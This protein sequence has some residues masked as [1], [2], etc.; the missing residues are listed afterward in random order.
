MR[1]YDDLYGLV[2]FNE[3]ERQT[4]DHPMF[5]RLRR[6]KQLALAEYIFPGATHSRF[7]HSLGVAD[8]MKRL[9]SK[10]LGASWER[11]D[12]DPRS[13]LSTL[14]MAAL[15]HDIGHLPLSH[16][17]EDAYEAQ[18][19]YTSELPKELTPLEAPK[20]ERQ[21]LHELLSKLVITKSPLAERLGELNFNAQDIGAIV[22]GG[23]Q[24]I[25]Y[26]QLLHS[27]LDVDQMDYLLRDAKATGINYGEYNLSY[28]LNNIR[29]DKTTHVLFV[30]EKALHTVEHF[31]L[32]K[33]FY[34]LQIL[35]HKKRDIYE[36][37][38]AVCAQWLIEDK[39]LQLNLPSLTELPQCIKSGEFSHLDDHRFFAALRQF[40]KKLKE[41][42]IRRRI[43]SILLDRHHVGVLTTEKMVKVDI[44]QPE[45]E[46]EDAHAV[47]ENEYSQEMKAL[48][49]Q[50]LFE[51]T[52]LENTSF[53][54]FV[55][56]EV[57]FYK[58]SS[59]TEKRKPEEG[60]NPETIKVGLGKRRALSEI[61][62]LP[63]S[64]IPPLTEYITVLYRYYY[65]PDNLLR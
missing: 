48:Q 54:P 59:E 5:Q 22:T 62:T 14:R 24:K 31:I 53:S 25:L 47:I 35:Y 65:Y 3:Y 46:T 42:D 4:I 60:P 11:D 55:R 18:I 27:D 20:D 30:D 8:L 57:S 37:L 13:P 17:L 61:N 15:L 34:F 63:Q 36:R 38:A 21:K 50:N 58:P 51:D 26:N 64:M 41:N 52:E 23:H 33:Y 44:L 12:K 49:G 43:C 28:L 19:G 1:V 45:N 40:Q 10:V 29:Q 7:S 9:A 6:V 39:E 2:E 16:S 56:H 32:A